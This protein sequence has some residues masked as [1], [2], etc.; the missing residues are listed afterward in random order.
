MEKVLEKK[1][2]SSYKDELI[3]FLKIHPQYFNEAIVLAIS[4][5]QPYAWRSSWL[6]W[7]CMKENDQRIRKNIPKIVKAIQTKK[8]GHQRELLKILY[9]MKLA[10]GHE[11]VLF[12]ICLNI[13]QQIDKNPSVRLNAFKFIVKIAKNHP[14]LSHEIDYLVQDHYLATLSPGVKKSISKM[15]KEFSHNKTEYL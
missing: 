8:D 1:L 4:D 12:D 9:Q 13:W 3:S 5:N 2:L 11:S 6:L 10:P 14:E 7:S 15:M